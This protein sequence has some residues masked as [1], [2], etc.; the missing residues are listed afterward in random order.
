MSDCPNCNKDFESLRTHLKE[1]PSHIPEERTVCHNCGMLSTQMGNHWRQNQSCD[2]PEITDYQ[3][4]VLTGLL[5]SDGWLSDHSPSTNCSIEVEMAN[6]EYLNYLNERVFPLLGTQVS[7]S[8]TGEECMS[9][10]DIGSD[11]PDD[12]SDIYS[13]RTIKHPSINKFKEWRE[14]GKKLWPSDLEM[15][16]TILKHL[17]VGDGSFH[18]K[19]E[20]MKI[21]T[22]NEMDNEEKVI[23]M[24]KSAGIQI[25]NFRYDKHTDKVDMFFSKEESKRLFGIMGSPPLGFEYKWPTEYR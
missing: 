19:D 10:T 8:R 23:N 25:N 15:N 9:P 12:Y 2:Y 1:N 24:F 22:V 6:E 11:N 7:L 18:Q 13:W 3:M 4:N 21:T 16:G 5:M 17:Y 14:Y 20:Y